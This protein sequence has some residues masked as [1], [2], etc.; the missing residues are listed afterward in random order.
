M[1]RPRIRSSSSARPSRRF[2]NVVALDRVSLTVPRGDFVTLLGPSGSGK[3]TLLRIVAGLEV[4]SEIA[5]LTISGQDV[6]GIPA[7]HR[8]VA[9]VFQHYGLFPH[10]SVGQNIEYGLLVRKRPA[11]RATPARDGRAR[12]GPPAGQVRPPGPPA[13]RRRATAHRA[14][15]RAGH[16]A[17]HPPARRA[18]GRARRAAAPRHA[19][20]AAA[21]AA[22]TRHHLHPGHAQPGRSADDERAHRAAEQGARRAGRHAAGPLRAADVTL[23]RQFHGH[24]KRARGRGR[25]RSATARRRSRS[26]AWRSP[27]ADRRRFAPAAGTPVFIAIRAE[28][29]RTSPAAAAAPRATPCPAGRGSGSTRAITT[30]SSSKPLSARS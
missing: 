12:D 11:G 22:G 3:T 23:R 15:P 2:G 30:T 24:R 14:R 16:R 18:A 17:R 8:N 29:L 21:P 7:N 28:R 9:T 6:R 25:P 20:R 5:E 27:A 1:T 26:T 13:E 10:M 19:G 4:P